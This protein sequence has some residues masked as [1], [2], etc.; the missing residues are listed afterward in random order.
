MYVGVCIPRPVTLL[1]IKMKT[2]LSLTL[3]SMPLCTR[4]HY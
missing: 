4:L 2:H 3:G 1:T